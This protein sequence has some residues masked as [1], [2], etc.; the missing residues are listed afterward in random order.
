MNTAAS[1]RTAMA[2]G[3]TAGIGEA[4]GKALAA[5]GA[6]IVVTGRSAENVAQTTE[7]LTED[8]VTADVG[9]SEAV[10]LP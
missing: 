3:C 1:E 6:S 10:D 8:G 4:T 2:T 7:R 9:T 5:A